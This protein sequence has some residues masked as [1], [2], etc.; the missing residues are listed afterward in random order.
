MG[1]GLN[2]M[3]INITILSAMDVKLITGLLFFSGFML[4]LK[5][6][7]NKGYIIYFCNIHNHI[8]TNGILL[9][10][11]IEQS[12]LSYLFQYNVNVQL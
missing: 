8:W 4:K 1:L 10:V 12:K 6:N 5:N 2:C 7:K 11:K 3:Y 9:Y